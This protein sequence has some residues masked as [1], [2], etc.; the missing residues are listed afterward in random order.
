MS[1]SII[2]TPD[3]YGTASDKLLVGKNFTG[4]LASFNGKLFVI[5][6]ENLPDPLN[7]LNLD[8]NTIRVKFTAGYTPPAE[9][10]DSQELVDSS[11]NVWDIYKQA[12]NWN[13]LFSGNHN[14]LE[15]LGGNTKNVTGMGWMFYNCTSLTRVALFSMENVVFGSLQNYA[16]FYKCS[17]L[18]SVPN[19]YFPKLTIIS[20]MFQECTSLT[21]VPVF[22]TAHVISMYNMFSGSTALTEVP[23]FNMENVTNCDY[24]FYNCNGLTSIP[25]LDIPKAYEIGRMFALC[26]NVEHG[27]LALYQKLSTQTNPPPNHTNTFSN[28]GSNTTTGLSELSQIPSDWK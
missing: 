26:E 17:S 2:K 14:L 19:F 10:G 3:G 5:D 21:T 9:L 20:M 27:A 7:P 6:L 8:P 25:L 15:V 11:N 16:M 12:N 23:V 4:D 18:V 28:C 22:D 13:Y 1:N 24:M